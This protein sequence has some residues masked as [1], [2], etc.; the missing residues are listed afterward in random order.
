[1][2]REREQLSDDDEEVEVF[3]QECK[4]EV[5]IHIQL[6]VRFKYSIYNKISINLKSYNLVSI[7]H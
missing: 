3:K 5:S 1:M 6:G 7:M 4:A 2:K